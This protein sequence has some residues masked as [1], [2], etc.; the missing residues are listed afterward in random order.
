L[1]ESRE[2]TELKHCG[3]APWKE[4]IGSVRFHPE[5]VQEQA[6]IAPLVSQGSVALNHWSEWI[7]SALQGLRR[8][9]PRCIRGYRWRRQLLNRK[10]CS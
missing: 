7:G 3:L 10:N 5:L 9:L 6:L 4:L 1:R 8:L 2:W